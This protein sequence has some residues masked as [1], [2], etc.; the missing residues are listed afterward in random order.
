MKTS[1]QIFILLFFPFLAFAQED[2][3]INF[4]RLSGNFQI[5]AQTYTKDSIIGAP[6]V[7][8][9]LLSNSF[10]N[11]NYILGDFSFGMRYEAYLNPIL[12]I[13]DRFAGQGIA[14]RYASYNTEMLDVTA[15]N[16]YEQFGSGMIFRAYEERALGLDNV[17]D[18]LRF[19]F[20]PFSGMELTGII[21]KQRNFWSLGEGI[22]R[23]GDLNISVN[24]LFKEPISENWQYSIGASIVSKFQEDLSSFYILPQNVMSYSARLNISSFEYSF[25][26]EYAYKINDPNITNGFN[27]SPGQGIIL[28]AAMFRDGLSA[29]VDAHWIDNMDFRSDRDATGTVLTLGFIPPLTKQHAFRLATTYPYATQFNGEGGVQAEVTYQIPKKSLLGGKYGAILNANIS[30]VHSVNRSQIDDYTHEAKIFDVSDRLYFQ[31]INFDFTKKWNKKLKTHLNYLNFIYD[32]DIVENEGSPK[33][34][35]VYSDVIIL[36]GTYNINPTNA[37]NIEVEHMWSRQDSAFVEPDNING[38]WIMLL[39]EY[40]I[41]P[42]FYITAWDEYNY[43]NDDEN[44]QIHYLNASFAYVFNTSRIQL[45]YG[46]QRGGII[47]VGGVCRPVPASN[48]FYLTLSSSF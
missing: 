40:T 4:G 31:D 34:G 36:Q 47:C 43:G 46:K 1:L 42:H 7:Q 24:D 45:S 27:Y 19:K 25:G 38:N 9:K 32:K 30:R 39:A 26:A 14:Y 2:V 23:G 15:G 13:D 10:I 37:I 29:S 8:E 12:G 35:K 33:F 11:L 17:M 48:G 16:F 3:P 44:R 18:G 41:A 22:V 6:E 28:N 5:E 21:G 20:R